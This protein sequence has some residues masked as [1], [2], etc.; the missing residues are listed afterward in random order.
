[1]QFIIVLAIFSYIFW[2]LFIKGYF[3]QIT[4]GLFAWVGM[5]GVLANA[6][7]SLSKPA[8]IIAGLNLSWAGVIPTIIVFLAFYTIQE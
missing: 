6:S 2:L 4:V 1:M 7:S 8:I 3:W 5:Y